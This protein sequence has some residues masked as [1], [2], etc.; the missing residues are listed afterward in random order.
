MKK[1][2][3]MSYFQP[4]QEAPSDERHPADPCTLL[5]SNQEYRAC[6]VNV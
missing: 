6:E 1:E 4:Q 5:G 2:M 3:K